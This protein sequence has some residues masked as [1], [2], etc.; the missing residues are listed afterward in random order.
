MFIND[1]QDLCP[2][3]Q[4]L[5]LGALEQ[6][7]WTPVGSAQPSVLKCRIMASMRPDVR[8]DPAAFNLRADLVDG[9]ALLQLTVPALRD[10]AEDVSDLLRQYVDRLV[11]LENLPYRRFSVAAQNRLRNYPWPGNI[12]ELPQLVRR[13]LLAGGSEEI[14]LAEVEA[15]ISE[16]A[17]GASQPLVQQDLL[18]CRCAK[19]AS[20][21]NVPT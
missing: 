14:D 1:L 10:H 11:E 8:R 9:L 4:R 12:E 15:A 2:E 7:A 18:T 13:V 16:A 3:A 20:N 5:L 19:P 17:G 6:G 21:S